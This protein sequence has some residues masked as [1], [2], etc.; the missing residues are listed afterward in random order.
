MKNREGR[1]CGICQT[2]VG[3]FRKLCHHVGKEHQQKASIQSS[4]FDSE[5]AYSSWLR[6][7]K[8]KGCVEF[9][10]C[11]AHK[12]E[13]EEFCWSVTEVDS[14]VPKQKAQSQ[15][16]HRKVMEASRWDTIAPLLS[17]SKFCGRNSVSACLDHYGHDISTKYLHVSPF[18][19]SKI[20][21]MVKSKQK[22]FEI[23]L[24][25]QT[26]GEGR[27]KTIRTVDIRNFIC[28]FGHQEYKKCDDD[29]T[30]VSIDDD[31]VDEIIPG[32]KWEWT[33]ISD[34]I[35]ELRELGME[36]LGKFSDKLE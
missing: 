9:I 20:V 3:D 2:R 34:V 33:D 15:K 35:K 12:G 13:M 31:A 11:M 5:G 6:G 14:F 18:S 32:A 7:V 27:E 4:E 23:A 28:W 24:K 29:A 16:G 19:Q 21:H 25:L 22:L 8:Q 36:F 17:Q 1:L 26:E 30:S 10:K